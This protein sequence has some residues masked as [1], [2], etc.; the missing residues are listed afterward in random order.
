[1]DRINGNRKDSIHD[2]QHMNESFC[3]IT[4][5]RTHTYTFVPNIDT[6]KHAQYDI[7]LKFGF[8]LTQTSK[9]KRKLLVILFFFVWFKTL[10]CSFESIH[11]NDLMILLMIIC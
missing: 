3:H 6:I 4:D 2:E 11:L 7:L 8:S 5:S 10:I 9:T 1:M